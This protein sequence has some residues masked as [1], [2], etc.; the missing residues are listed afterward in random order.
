M[1]ARYLTFLGL[2]GAALVA[3]LSCSDPIYATIE[4]EKKTDTN[5]LGLTLNIYD[6]AVPAPGNYY[7]AAGGVFQGI[8][9]GTTV[10]WTPNS[11]DSSRPFNPK[12]AIC[13]ALAYLLSA[14]RLFGGFF[15]QSGNLGLYKSASGGNYSFGPGYGTP[16]TATASPGEQVT[17]LRSANGVLFMGGTNAQGTYELDYS[18]TDGTTWTQEIPTLAYPI[19]GVG[20]DGPTNENYWAVSSPT[21]PPGSTNTTTAVVYKSN[22][23]P[24]S[25]S[26]YLTSPVP[27]GDQVNGVFGDSV[28]PTG[29]H[30]FLATRQNGIYWSKDGGS[31]WYNISAD[32]Q[33]NLPVSYLC[34]A[35]PVD[36]PGGSVYIAGSDGYGYYTFTLSDSSLDHDRFGDS[37]ILLYTSSVSCV[38]ADNLGATNNVLMGTNANGLWR[39][40]FDSSGNLASGQSW[41]HE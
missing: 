23:N 6:I 3:L 11:N 36:S 21:V 22:T 18:L 16:I 39:G 12:G 29:G 34:V 30:V 26:Q 37:T 5:T 35:G 13:N 40:V 15:T 9:N 32:S 27:S 7:V 14:N 17:L 25:F 41:T 31:N 10:T 24:T 8:L 4:T 20:Y 33:N 1:K 28:G 19:T 38:A 2:F